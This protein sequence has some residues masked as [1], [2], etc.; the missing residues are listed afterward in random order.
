MKIQYNKEF[1]VGLIF[2][3]STGIVGNMWVT[4][5]YRLLDKFGE[6]NINILN[7][8]VDVD[9]LIF[10]IGL[11]GFSLIVWMLFRELK[12]QKKS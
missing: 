12:S 8:V 7:F 10:F 5:L 6:K 4:S 3:I 11:I 2:G 9:I 1:Y